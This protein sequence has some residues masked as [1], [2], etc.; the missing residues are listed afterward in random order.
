MVV[1][2]WWWRAVAMELQNNVFGQKSV[3][4]QQDTEVEV[5]WRIFLHINC[6]KYR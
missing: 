6:T 5:F 3:V 4:G 1:W 2:Y